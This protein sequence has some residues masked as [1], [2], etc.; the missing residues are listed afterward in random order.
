MSHR[1]APQELF[2]LRNQI[3]LREVMYALSVP[4]KM[5]DQ[6]FRFRCPKCGHCQT[7]IHPRENL[8]RC[9]DCNINF[10]TIDMI[11]ICKNLQFR[12]A[13]EWLQALKKV[14]ADADYPR[15]ISVMAK[16]SRMK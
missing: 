10:N 6:L 12:S 16:R 13:I 3:P 1:I 4:W 11:C 14:M 15:L 5:E 7:S 8:G 9:F 2:H